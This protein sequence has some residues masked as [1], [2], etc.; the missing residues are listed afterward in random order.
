VPPLSFNDARAVVFREVQSG[1]AAPRVEVVELGACHGRVLAEDVVADRD[2]PPFDRS[3]RDGFAVQA[4][5]IPGDLRLIGE[6]RAG[7]TFSGEIRPGEAV[8][9][10]TGAPVPAGGD[11]VVMVE[12]CTR[13]NNGA[14]SI[15]QPAA[16]RTNISISGSEAKSGS[17]V[18]SRGTRLDYAGV[19]CLASVGKT[20]AQVFS[21][22]SVAILST[23]DEIVDVGETP[24]VSQIRNSNAMSLVAQVQRAGGIPIILPVA[25]DTKEHTSELIEQGLTTDLLLISGGVSAGK[26]DVVEPVLSELGAAFFF[27]RVL[28]Q[29]GQPAV[30]GRAHGRFFFGLPGNPVSTMITFEIFA[31]AALQLLSGETAPSLPLALARLTCPLNHRPGLT[32]FLPADLRGTDV[33]PVS[34]NGS[35]DLPSLCRSN[36]Y[37]MTD[38][39]RADY[40]AGEIIS[41]LSK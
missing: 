33:T 1:M 38:S 23:G 30:F 31:R 36:T 20:S 4:A 17:I 13:L 9:I 11:A 35:G 12:H 10:M 16:S 25:R 29:P 39:G 5:S 15:N 37:L 18:V 21:R 24:S 34:W 40:A 19:A 26:Y 32:R 2:Y 22:P 14:I 41:I 27:D 3:M 6:V 8:E 7:G 28:I